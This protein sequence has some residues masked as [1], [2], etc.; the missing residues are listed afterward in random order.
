MPRSR[1]NNTP[2]KAA[3][4]SEGQDGLRVASISAATWTVTRADTTLS[5]AEVDGLEDLLA[6]LLA[7]R[8]R[9]PRPAQQ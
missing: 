8:L 7:E 5:A 3:P 4:P 9:R 6:A 2:A 1:K